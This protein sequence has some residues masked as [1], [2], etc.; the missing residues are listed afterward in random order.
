M[1]GLI[2]WAIHACLLAFSPVNPTNYTPVRPLIEGFDTI[3]VTD[4]R[5]ALVM[6]FGSILVGQ[7]RLLHYGQIAR[8]RSNVLAYP[9]AAICL[10][11]VTWLSL[12]RKLSTL[13]WDRDLI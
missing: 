10:T 9:F 7:S 2:F 4:V 13:Q 3:S 12:Q 5:T 11:A 1:F 8:S 6:S